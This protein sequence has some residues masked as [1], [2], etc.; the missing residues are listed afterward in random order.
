MQ[1]VQ[2]KDSSHNTRRSLDVPG[3]RRMGSPRSEE[4]RYT[5]GSLVAV[6]NSD[7]NEMAVMTTMMISSTL[8]PPISGSVGALYR[9]H[10][11]G[12]DRKRATRG[13]VD[14]KPRPD[15]TTH[16]NTQNVVMGTA[17]R[18]AVSTGCQAFSAGPIM[19]RP[20]RQKRFS[21]PAPSGLS[22]LT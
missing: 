21:V 17:T 20:S 13:A 11:R 18:C 3:Q 8:T 10:R 4:R 15:G 9:R 19:I 16:S 12:R 5:P 2:T 7:H 22:L 1:S 6:K 14:G